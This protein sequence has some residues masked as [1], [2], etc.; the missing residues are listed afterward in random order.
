MARIE[1]DGTLAVIGTAGRKDDAK[2]INAGLYDAMYDQTLAAM[3]DWNVDHLISG[4]A[5]VADHLAVRAFLNGQAE[6]LTL[7][8]PAQFD[9]KRLEYFGNRDASTANWY[10]HQFSKACGIDSLKE[11]GE[12]IA[13]GAEIHVGRGFKDRNLFVARN[14]TH[15]LALTFGALRAPEDLTPD[16]EGF[17]NH[18]VA[19]LK[20]G[21]TAHTFGEA[22]KCRLKRHV[23]LNWLGLELQAQPGAAPGL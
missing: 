17:S 1:N 14:A 22:W 18:R 2:R 9:P 19:G 11:L 7:A 23:S 3:Q 10:Y 6:K 4:G 15:L 16:S 8:L 20:D 12:A 5:A 21:G 13:A